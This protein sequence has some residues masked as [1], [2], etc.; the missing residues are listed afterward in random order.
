MLSLITAIA[1]GSRYNR[2]I[3]SKIPTN[4]NGPYSHD[5]APKTTFEK[6]FNRVYT[7]LEAHSVSPPV[8]P[9]EIALV[10]IIMAQGTMFNIE[11]A[12]NDSSAEELLHLSESALVRG[13]FLSNNTVA[14]LQTLVGPGGHCQFHAVANTSLASDGASTPVR[15]MIRSFLAL[16]TSG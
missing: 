10:F 1:R 15:S 9:Q 16:L 14:G 11:T 4:K 2:R 3:A 6:T 5:V 13:D 12:D 8:D 7:L